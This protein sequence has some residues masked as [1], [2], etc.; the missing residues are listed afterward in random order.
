[1]SDE[2]DLSLY[3]RSPQVD[4]PS[5]YAL[6]IALLSAVPKE[7]PSGSPARA[8]ARRLR[9]ALMTL[10]EAWRAR[11]KLGPVDRRPFD[12]VADA[13]WRAL[14]FRLEAAAQLSG[15]PELDEIATEARTL[16]G[17]L[18]TSGLAFIA[19]PY[20]SQ[21]AH[22]DRL[23]QA[24]DKDGL[25]RRVDRIAGEPYLAFVRRA[26]EA[27]GAALRITAAASDDE[28]EV[29]GGVRE[30]LRRVQV[31]IQEYV[32]AV[33]AT[34]PPS[35]ASN[36]SILR[37]AFAPIDAHRTAQAKARVPGAPEPPPVVDPA[38]PSPSD[39]IPQVD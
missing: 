9:S 13:A 6:G 8:A 10:S 1:M 39:P 31:A 22:A 36:V 28:V 12:A 20:P 35:K 7:V 32:F 17:Q 18:F 16:L 25:A 19:L 11:E 23:L 26:H 15:T 30:P 5:G 34:L 14:N 3:T 2:L 38:G 27:Y 24:I 33:L 29:G 4:L 37:R 21:W